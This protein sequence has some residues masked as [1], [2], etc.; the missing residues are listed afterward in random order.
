MENLFELM[1]ANPDTGLG[2]LPFGA[3]NTQHKET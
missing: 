3:N 2:N 1:A